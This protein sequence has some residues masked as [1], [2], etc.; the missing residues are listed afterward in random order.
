MS[1]P[2]DMHEVP[3]DAAMPSGEMSDPEIVVEHD[4][5]PGGSMDADEVDA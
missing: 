3:P 5:M 2:G 4:E 1:D